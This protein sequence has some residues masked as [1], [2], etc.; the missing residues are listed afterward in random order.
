MEWMARSLERRVNPAEVLPGCRSVICLSYDYDSSVSRP[1]GSGSICLYAHGRDYHGI[2]EEKL[3]DLSELLSIYGGEQKGYVDAGPVMERDHAEACGLG[4]RGRSG[5]IVRRRGG[6]RF[7][8]ATLL[9]TL[10]LEP[11]APASGT[12]G[13]CRRCVEACPAGAIMENGLVDANRCLSYWT[14]EHRG[15]IPE[16]IRP[17]I[18]G[19][20]EIR[21]EE[22][23]PNY[24]RYEYTATAPGTAI[25][26]EIYY[27]DGWTAYI[28]G[29]ETPYFRADYLLRGMELPAGTHTVEW[30][31][32]A[33]GWNVA[34]GVTL[35]SSLA[36]LAGIIA[37]VILVLRH[38]R[39]QKT[40]A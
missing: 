16:D 10:E 21:L 2:L 22:Y 23:R 30:R 7:F 37:T 31:F 28:D 3:A 39:L 17:L 36:I 19:E 25:F 5:L 1:S 27:K 40:Q 11:D 13:S 9:T 33:P 15:A 6:S 26:S 29:I 8:I 12:C 35:A 24:L 34:E 4:W 18:G 14:I 32:R 20:G 38:E